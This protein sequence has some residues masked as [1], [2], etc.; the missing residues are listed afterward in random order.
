MKPCWNRRTKGNRDYLALYF[1]DPVG[2]ALENREYTNPEGK[3]IILSPGQPHFYGTDEKEW[4][5]SWIHFSGILVEQT[6]KSA[7]LPL[8]QLID[9]GGPEEFEKLLVRLHEEIYYYSPPDIHIMENHVNTGLISISRSHKNRSSIS[10]IPEPFL[11]IKQLLDFQ[12]Y[13]EF[14]ISTL[15]DRTNYS[16]PHFCQKFK[17]FFQFSPIDYLVNKRIQMAKYFLK[18]TNLNIGEISQ[19]IGYVDIYYFSRLFKKKTGRSP[20]SYRKKFFY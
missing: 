17:S 3:W 12:Y 16:S 19:K 10:P 15:A 7:S 14:S 2:F 5:H 8:N 13:K 6:I 20:S 4:S 1:H 9:I 11:G 18:T